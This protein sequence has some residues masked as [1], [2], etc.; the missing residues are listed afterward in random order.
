[1]EEK[2]KEWKEK[3]KKERKG[4][5]KREKGETQKKMVIRIIEPIL[6]IASAIE[7]SQFPLKY[8]LIPFLIKGTNF[9]MSMFSNL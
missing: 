1:M 9:V 6:I 8:S 7:V 4:N 3:T 2:K 5:E